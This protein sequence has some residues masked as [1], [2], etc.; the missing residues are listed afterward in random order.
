[1]RPLL[2][3]VVYGCV[4]DHHDFDVQVCVPIN[5]LSAVK[6]PA[7]IIGFLVSFVTLIICLAHFEAQLSG[8]KSLS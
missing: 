3:A 6:F 5:L 7:L 2:A 1:M 8:G 4:S